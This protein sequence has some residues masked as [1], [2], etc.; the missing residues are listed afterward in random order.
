MNTNKFYHSVYLQTELCRGCIHCLK[1]CPTQAIRVNN[2]KASIISEFCIDCSECITHCPYHAKVTLH[3]RLSNLGRYKY[4]V[5]LV[6]PSI[7]GQFNNL[8]D[9]NILLSGLIGLGFDDVFEVG[10]AYEYLAEKIRAYID[11]E[12]PDYPLINST[13]PSIT[14]L[15]RVRFPNLIDYMVPM[16]SPAE[17]A[18]QAALAEATKRSGLPR[19]E[20]GIVYISPCPALISYSKAPLGTKETHIDTC[21]AMK[22]LY[23]P[24][25]ATMAN[26]R[27]DP[28]PLSRVSKTGAR[29][30]M[31]SAE[32]KSLHL[33][34]FMAADG[35][36]NVIRVLNAVEDE[37]IPPYMQYIEL[38]GCSAGC[39]GGVLNVENPFI[40]RS[41][42]HN[43][44]NACPPAES[45][46]SYFEEECGI[47][48]MWTE[49]ITYET[50]YQ[51]GDSMAES[52][53]K[54]NTVEQILQ[55][56]PR[57]DCGSCGAPT[58]R[59]MAEDIVRG[60]PGASTD[61]CIYI[62]RGSYARLQEQEDYRNRRKS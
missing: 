17:I 61:R 32:A 42:A 34:H 16:L 20:I 36:E 39:V 49:P 35:I 15:I 44:A 56:L 24:L 43:L 33:D 47:D 9:P 53:E 46:I 54:M 26:M 14:R 27:N 41:K 62:M 52:M 55:R 48:P 45:R 59:T 28:I 22:D 6:D 38:K 51:L 5:A 10:L 60:V 13:C 1:R 37:K 29:S 12:K 21:L 30:G 25:L 50:V 57:L 11:E 3:D 7:Y 31:I 58:C 40:A 23:K 8:T 19:E 4:K 2:R 18:A